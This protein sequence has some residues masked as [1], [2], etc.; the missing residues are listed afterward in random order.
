MRVSKMQNL[1]PIHTTSNPRE[2]ATQ[3]SLP[4]FFS[5]FPLLLNQQLF[6]PSF[7]GLSM[8]EILYLKV[9]KGKLV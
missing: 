7:L 6:S 5:P 9:E 4:P 2:L 3:N 1:P 8:K